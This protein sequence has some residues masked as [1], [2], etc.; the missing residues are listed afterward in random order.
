MKELTE[1]ESVEVNGGSLL[2]ATAIFLATSLAYD[3]LS[4]GPDSAKS[5]KEGYQ[6]GLNTFN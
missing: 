1:K 4:N 5:F 3:I 2:T 6:R